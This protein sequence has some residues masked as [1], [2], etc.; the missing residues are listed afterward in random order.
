MADL[1]RRDGHYM[2]SLRRVGEDGDKYDHDGISS[3]DLIELGLAD[4]VTEVADTPAVDIESAARGIPC[5]GAIDR[6]DG[7]Q[8]GRAVELTLELRD[9]HGPECMA[10]PAVDGDGVDGAASISLVESGA[11]SSDVDDPVLPERSLDDSL[12]VLWLQPVPDVDD[13]PQASAPQ[14]EVS[15]GERALQL[16]L[17]FFKSEGI[18]PRGDLDFLVDIIQERGWTSVQFQVRGLVRAG[19]E[20]VQVH[21]MFELTD[22]WLHCVGSDSLVP[23]RW[24][25]GK[26]LTWL[27]AAQLLD[28]L[29][30]DVGIDRIVDFLA[31]EKEI[32]QTL[33]RGSGQ[34]ATFKNYLF[35]YRLSP[36]SQVDDGI[37]QANLD[38]GDP[39]S[40]DGT[41][42]SLYALAWWDEP[43]EGNAWTLRQILDSCHDLGGLAE[44]LEPEDR[45]Y[46]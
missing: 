2:G 35:G 31:E 40:F 12:D 21:R 44:W 5:A 8:A 7:V 41:R 4:L 37:W 13:D 9:Q 25:G 33:R 19:Y 1:V 45:G 42:N 17:E 14:D 29:G 38:P 27:E 22:A 32:W 18:D 20:I 23:E 28:F 39:R 46:I 10:T 43:V 24:H 30:Y 34:L 6:G 36:R 15:A 26:R 3:H 16:A 11:L